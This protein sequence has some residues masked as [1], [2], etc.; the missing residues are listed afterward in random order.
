MDPRPPRITLV[1]A[2]AR[3]G[4]IGRDNA[5]PWHLPEDLQH[6]KATTLGHPIV[7]GRRTFESIGRPLPGRR[8]L[9][10]SRDPAWAHPG[11]ERAGSLDEAIDLCAGSPEVFVVGGAQLYAAA[12]PRADRLIL[13][14][15]DIEVPGD[16]FFPTPDPA[17]WRLAGRIPAVSRTGLAYAIDTWEPQPDDGNPR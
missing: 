9:V 3:N 4:A 15:V 17:R 2:R 13:T 6:F 12:M 8:T 16:A 7:M 10:V 11:C 14:E 5:L 1:A